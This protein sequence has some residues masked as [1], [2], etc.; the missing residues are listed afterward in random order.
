[1]PSDFHLQAHDAVPVGDTATAHVHRLHDAL[2]QE[3]E[4]LGRRQGSTRAAV[5]IAHTAVETCMARALRSL[6]EAQAPN[7]ADAMEDL[8]D[9]FGL[10]RPR[11]QKLWEA[12]T[13]EKLTQHQSWANYRTSAELRNAVVHRG[14][15][16]SDVQAATA[17]DVTRTMIDHLRS[18]LD[19][20]GVQHDLHSG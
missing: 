18:T 9:G 5:V 17:L 3:A 16:V 6:L 4:L 10:L 13:G 20:R 14:E 19:A 12:L 1:M 8:L 7:V 15:P 2:L 11:I